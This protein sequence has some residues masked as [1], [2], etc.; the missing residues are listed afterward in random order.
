M[1]VAPRLTQTYV[2]WPYRV[3]LEDGR[4]NIG[5]I[6]LT[7]EPERLNEIHELDNM[8]ILKKRIGLLNSENNGVMTLGI[9][10]EQSPDDNIW[11]SCFEFGFRPDYDYSAINLNELDSLFYNYLSSTQGD[12]FS[13]ALQPHLIWEEQNVTLYSNKPSHMYSVFLP[14]SEQAHIEQGFAHLVDWLRVEFAVS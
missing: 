9:L 12:G 3:D 6:D 4:T 14:A 2:Q 1:T 10:C 8:P 7:K 13:K 11:Y 5:A